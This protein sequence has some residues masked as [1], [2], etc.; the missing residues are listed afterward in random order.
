ME[1]FTHRPGWNLRRWGTVRLRMT[2]WIVTVLALI[3]GVM[4]DMVRYRVQAD[5]LAM[6]DRTLA[7]RAHETGRRFSV[8]PS[9][10]GRTRRDPGQSRLLDPMTAGAEGSQSTHLQTRTAQKYRE[11]IG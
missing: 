7:E 10:P 4:G 6:V 3:R 1:G 9:P 5:R 8:A 2:L 11:G